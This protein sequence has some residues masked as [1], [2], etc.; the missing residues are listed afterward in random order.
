MVAVP[1]EAIL[2]AMRL[3]ARLGGVFGEPAGVTGV[4]GLQHA[5]AKGIVK[6]EESALCVITGNGLKDIQTAAQAA[7]QAQ[8]IDPVFAALEDKVKDLK[9][10]EHHDA[11]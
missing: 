5:L 7:G 3:T 1:D 9:L 2:E 4:A 10:V 8:D 6:K 11:R